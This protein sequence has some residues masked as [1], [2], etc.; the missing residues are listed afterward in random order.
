MSRSGVEG[1]GVMEKLCL[2]ALHPGT[3][4]GIFTI[5]HQLLTAEGKDGIIRFV[6]S[7]PAVLII[8]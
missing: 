4:D 3:H 5:K 1:G 2:G 6:N 8:T 7:S